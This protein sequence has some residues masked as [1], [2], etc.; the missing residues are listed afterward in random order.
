MGGKLHIE[1]KPKA[2]V[3]LVGLGGTDGQDPTA[4]LSELGLKVE[5]SGGKK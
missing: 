3:P 1:M 5:Q 4:V 2:P